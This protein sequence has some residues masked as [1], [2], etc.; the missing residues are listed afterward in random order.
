VTCTS[1]P[2]RRSGRALPLEKRHDIR[3]ERGGDTGR[4]HEA[5]HPGCPRHLVRLSGEVNPREQIARE[6]GHRAPSRRRVRRQLQLRIEHVEALAAQ[7]QLGH[8]LAVR[9]RIDD[10]PGD[11]GGR[12]RQPVRHHR[13]TAFA[14]GASWPGDGRTGGWVQGDAV[15]QLRGLS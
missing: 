8:A 4:S 15:S 1:C 11:G 2:R 13:R 7:V 14:G 5:L 3:I 12:R 9:L 6:E 10:V